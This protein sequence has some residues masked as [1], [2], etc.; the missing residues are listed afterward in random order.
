MSSAR[1]SM[2][3]CQMPEF[4]RKFCLYLSY[5]ISVQSG[6]PDLCSS[7]L[8]LLYGM[9]WLLILINSCRTALFQA[10]CAFGCRPVGNA[11]FSCSCPRGYDQFGQDQ[12]LAIN[13]PNR[14]LSESSDF[15]TFEYL[16]EGVE[17]DKDIL[18]TEGCFACDLDGSKAT[19]KRKKIRKH[20]RHRKHRR[21]RTS[22]LRR[23]PTSSRFNLI[24]TDTFLQRV[25][26]HY[27]N[28][29]SL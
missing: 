28:L 27:I 29:P 7:I 4:N 24:D 3:K 14:F 21:D 19:T 20:R 1:E 16:E 18:T 26:L 12:C 25:G 9:G 10:S 22:R 23:S 6:S 2:W 17:L 13:D 15:G 11:G 8:G 5:R